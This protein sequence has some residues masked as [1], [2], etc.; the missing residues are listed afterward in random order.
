MLSVLKGLFKEPLGMART[1]TQAQ[2]HEKF[3]LGYKELEIGTLTFKDGEWVFKYSDEF[4][5]QTEIQAMIDFPDTNKTYRSDELWP[6]FLSR[7]PGLSQ[8]AVKELLRKEKINED[9]EAALLKRFG[10]TSI[11]SPFTLVPEMA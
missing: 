10:K 11:T 7:I 5:S 6:F 3:E 8:P 1:K 2:S 4:K 9:D